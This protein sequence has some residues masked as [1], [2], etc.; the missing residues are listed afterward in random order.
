MDWFYS[1]IGKFAGSKLKLE[2]GLPMDTKPWYKSKTIWSDV[3]TILIGIYTMA[4]GGLAADLGHTLPSIPS[5]VLAILGG[6]GI[7][8][9]ATADTTITK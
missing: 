5:W 1:L 3:V 8:G 4:Q 6:I 9:R 7:Y 2:D